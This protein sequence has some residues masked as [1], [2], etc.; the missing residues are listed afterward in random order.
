VIRPHALSPLDDNQRLL[1]KTITAGSHAVQSA[2]DVAI[3]GGCVKAVR[4]EAVSVTAANIDSRE[5]HCA[6]FGFRGMDGAFLSATPASAAR[7][8][9]V[10]Y[11]TECASRSC[12]ARTRGSAGTS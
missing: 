2:V 5:L 11:G 9:L 3:C 6:E 7:G 10:S 4:S 1:G 12:A 8:R